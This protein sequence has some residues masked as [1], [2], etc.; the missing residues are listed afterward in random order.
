VSQSSLAST[1]RN[2]VGEDARRSTRLERSVPLIIFGQNRMGEPFVERTVSVSVNLHGCRYPSRHDYGVGS[3]VTLQ[4]VGLIAEPKPPSVRAR[5]RSVHTSQSSRELQ[6]VGVELENPANVWGIVSPPEDWLRFEGSHVPATPFAVVPASAQDA[7]VM[8]DDVA[9]PSIHQ[10]PKLAEVTPFP[11]PPP[12][13]AMPPVAQEI[14]EPKPRRVVITPDALVAALQGKL[15]QAAEKAAQ[16][17]VAKEVDE[18]VHQALAA[19]DGARQSSAQE[20][21]VLSSKQNIPEETASR[22][23]QQME[24]IRGRVEEIAQRLEQQAAEL[25]RELAKSQEFVEKMARE[26]EPQIHA[27]LNE[28]VAQATSQFEDAA[29]RAVDRRYERLLENSQI[30]TQEALLKLDAR[31]AEVQALVQSAVNSALGVFQRQTE[32]HANLALSEAKERATSALASLDAESRAACEARRQSVETEVARAA[33]RSTE[34]FRKG[35]KA[36]LYSCLVAAVSA[37]DEHSKATLEGLLKDNG[38]TLLEADSDSGAKNSP[39]VIPG[40]DIDPL[41]H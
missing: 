6:Q 2:F 24:L 11:A 19:I 38:K 14:E 9:E 28:A 30:I 5:V 31:S 10:E 18:A 3:W 35:M 17:A 7:T 16:A 13:V 12:T 21:Q 33:E 1:P 20:L 36:F 32:M 27:R 29:A 25:R 15:Q 26:I 22:W 23:N 4:V 41:T 34:Q 8:T 40:T 39:D 37:V